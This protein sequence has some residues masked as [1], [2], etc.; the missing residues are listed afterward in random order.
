MSAGERSKTDQEMSMETERSWA[1]LTA[2]E[3]LEQRFQFYTGPR[4]TEGTA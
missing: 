2:D 4:A 3:K 1:G